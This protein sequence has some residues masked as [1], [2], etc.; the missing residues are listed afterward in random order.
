MTRLEINIEAVGEMTRLIFTTHFN[1]SRMRGTPVLSAAVLF[2]T[3]FE[4]PKTARPL[5]SVRFS[6]SAS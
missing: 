1:F 2:P 5:S 3:V 4:E 6:S